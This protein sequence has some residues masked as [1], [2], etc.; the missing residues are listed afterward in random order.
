MKSLD[1]IP[2]HIPTVKWP[3]V[4]E[5]Y[6]TPCAQKGKGKGKAVDASSS[7]IGDCDKTDEIEDSGAQMRADYSLMFHAAFKE[8]IDAGVTIYANK[9]RPKPQQRQNAAALAKQA[10]CPA[11]LVQ[12]PDQD[13]GEVSA[14]SC[15]PLVA[16]LER[17]GG[18]DES[19]GNSH[20]T[21]LRP[22][23]I[24]STA[25]RLAS[26][27][28]PLRAHSAMAERGR[29]IQAILCQR[30]ASLLPQMI[31]WDHFT[32]RHGSRGKQRYVFEP[33]A[34]CHSPQQP[35]AHAVWT[36]Q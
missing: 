29:R 9:P 20:W 11:P 2:D 21:G 23:R 31:H 33:R 22:P 35:T 1:E 6:S 30:Q 36:Q 27:L 4:I 13:S 19:S 3:W 16:R 12:N 8:R 15:V 10:Q 24:P 32:Y 17:R 26:C 34:D 5:G 25:I 18:H 28:S 7:S 14:I